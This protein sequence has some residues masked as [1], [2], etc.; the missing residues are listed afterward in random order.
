MCDEAKRINEA[1]RQVLAGDMDRFETLYQ[2]T[3]GPLRE[4][5][6]RKYG[7]LGPDFVDEV[8][9]RTHEYVLNRLAEYDPDRGPFSTWMIWWAR[10]AASLVAKSRYGRSFEPFDPDWYTGGPG[11]A[12]MQELVRRDRSIRREVQALP[13]SQRQ[14]IELRYYHN[15]TRE[16]T[17]ARLNLKIGSVRRREARALKRLKLRLLERKVQIVEQDA[18]PIPV[19]CD[20]QATGYDDDWTAT[21]GAILPDE[22]PP[23]QDRAAKDEQDDA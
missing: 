14:V 23:L 2:L 18:T 11:P 3:N 9:V 22:P 4:F 20:W 7:F 21:V 10:H 12:E 15:Q 19:W 5:I 13:E 1:V 6:G 16:Q 17:A 8:R